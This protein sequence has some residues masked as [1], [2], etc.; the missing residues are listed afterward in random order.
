[1]GRLAAGIV[2]GSAVYG[3]AI[4]WIHS[5]GQA[6]RSAVKFPLLIGL[7]CGL[8]VVSYYLLCQF[9]TRALTMGAVWRLTLR[10]FSGTALLLASLSPAVFFTACVAERP[11]L[12]G[13]NEY[14]FFLGFNV[15]LIAV[16]GTVALVREGRALMRRHRLSRRAAQAVL[17]MWLAVSLF[18]G[19]QCAWYLRPFFGPSTME[20]MPFIAGSAP[21]MRG[22][23]SFYEAVYH[24]VDPPPLPRDYH[25]HP[26]RG[27]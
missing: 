10:V 17:L 12:T 6:C 7:T 27:R 9:V 25:R 8:C 11:D 13:L 22:A 19:G 14:P 21:D 18:A 1:M 15:A 16:S 20:A 5:P 23:T 24:L 3:F 4:G 2:A 26:S